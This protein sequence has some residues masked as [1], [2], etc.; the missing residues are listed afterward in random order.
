MEKEVKSIKKYTNPG[1]HQ[2]RGRERV[3]GEAVTF[4]LS[5]EEWIRFRDERNVT[6]GREKKHKQRHECSKIIRIFRK[7]RIFHNQLENS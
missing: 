5:C 4:E 1:G 2:L 7:W 6:A 3:S